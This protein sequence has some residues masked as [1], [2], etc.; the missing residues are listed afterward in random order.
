[1]D[2]VVAIDT[3]S[4]RRR[5]LSVRT[6]SNL[7]VLRSRLH[8]LQPDIAIDSQGVVKSALI[9]RLSGAPVRIGLARPWR[10]ELLPGL[11]YTST[12][13]G[14]A[15]FRHVVATNVELVRAVGGTP[16]PELPPPDGRWLLQ[17]LAGTSQVLPTAPPYLALLPGAGRTEKVIPAADLGAVSRWSADHGLPALVLW[18][19]GEEGRAEAVVEASGGAASKAPHTDLDELTIALAGARAVIGGD[20]GPVHLAASLSVPTLGVFTATDWR[21][22][23][24]LGSRVAVV[25]GAV[26]GDWRPTGSPWA[27]QP[28]PVSAQEIIDGLRALL[29]PGDD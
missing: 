25:S 8:E 5:P 4:W 27:E 22:N 11:A 12:L 18:G 17:H 13:P 2:A 9:A 29:E 20:T 16:P 1:V 24:P 3:K 23:G 28:G 21:R 14:S 10:R 6:R 19:P 15:A 7:S 26:L